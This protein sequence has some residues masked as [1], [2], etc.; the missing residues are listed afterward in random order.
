MNTTFTNK[1]KKSLQLTLLVLFTLIFSFNSIAQVNCSCPGN[2]VL[3]PSFESG[4]ASWN[5]SGGNLNAGTGAV[6][7][8]SYSGDFEITNTTN[9]Y[10]GQTI[11]NNW[12]YTGTVITAS[13]Y[14]GTHDPSYY[15]QVSIDF[16]DGNWAW[17]SSS[18]V[19]VNKLLSAAPAGPQ[20]YTWTAT[21]PGNCKYVN[22]NA[23][24]N[25]G[26]IRQK[27]ATNLLRFCFGKRC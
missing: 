2:L 25:N 26:F 24:G 19:E 1:F 6:A 9:N 8:G 10:M 5:W 15:H 17:I 27:M 20:L 14:A 13:V 16:F 22:V 12:P 21:V 4:T 18:S 23:S 3:N 11:F 7:C